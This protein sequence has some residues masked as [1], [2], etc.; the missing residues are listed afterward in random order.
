MRALLAALADDLLE[1]TAEAKGGGRASFASTSF[2]CCCCC[3]QI[4][5]PL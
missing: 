4:S 5:E 1:L 3:S 2:C